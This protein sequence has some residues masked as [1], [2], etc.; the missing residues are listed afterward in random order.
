MHASCELEFPINEGTEQWI[1]MT[2]SVTPFSTTLATLRAWLFGTPE[3]VQKNGT[4]RGILKNA[5]DPSLEI[6]FGS[7][8]DNNL[9]VNAVWQKR[10]NAAPDEWKRYT[11]HIEKVFGIT[12]EEE[13]R[14]ASRNET[15]V[16]TAELRSQGYL[17]TSAICITVGTLSRIMFHRLNTM[18]AHRLGILY[19][20]IEKREKG[21]GL[22]TISNHQSVL[23]DPFLLGSLL[24]ARILINAKTM[25]W[26][27]CSLDIC[28]QNE[29]ISR[30]LRVGKALPIQRRGGV[31][32]KFLL[33]AG[34]KLSDG[35]WV[36]MF[37][38]GR[39]RQRG[40]GYFKRGV[41]KMLA[42]AYEAN[43]GRLPLIIPV[44][45]E[46]IEKVMP[47]RVDTNRLESTTPKRGK[48]LYFVAGEP[49]DV[50]HIF[51]RLMPECQASGG[52]AVDAPPCMKLYEEVADFMAIVMRLLRAEARQLIRQ[53]HNVDLGQAYEL[54]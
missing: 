24:P 26:S 2:D 48:S 21:Q 35:D 15:Y 1:S 5:A 19:D 34:K 4:N 23:D 49:V 32:Q 33:D 50:T 36:H 51:N 9:G 41:G 7:Q 13:L 12:D 20:A 54:S 25:R 8:S 28:F 14:I 16:H 38:E 17:G 11:A 10:W 27:L 44:Y 53:E 42:M 31:S 30:I 46:G 6:R 29:W 47:Q 3:R 45:H 40:M 52:T 43:T 39:I 37:P 18:H 22:L